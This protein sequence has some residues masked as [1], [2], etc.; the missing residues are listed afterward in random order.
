MT[1]LAWSLEVDSSVA[2]FLES[3]E[4]GCLAGSASSGEESSSSSEVVF[5]ASES[6]ASV[7]WPWP[8]WAG[9]WCAGLEELD[10]R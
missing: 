6:S 10:R 8:C 2:W 5:A 7:A 1:S 9:E 4:S 3:V